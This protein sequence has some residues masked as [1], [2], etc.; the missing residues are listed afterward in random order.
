MQEVESTVL[1]EVNDSE[2]RCSLREL[3]TSLAA[4]LRRYSQVGF[5]NPIYKK[6][7]G[8]PVHKQAFAFGQEKWKGI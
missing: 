1:M 3:F 8:A 5:S 7:S 2:G 6:S 4:R